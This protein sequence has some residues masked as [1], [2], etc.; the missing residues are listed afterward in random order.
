MESAADRTRVR[1]VQM[2]DR[3]EIAAFETDTENEVGL[4]EATALKAKRVRKEKQ[5][6]H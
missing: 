2:E 6:P 1:S 5:G 4:E 3:A